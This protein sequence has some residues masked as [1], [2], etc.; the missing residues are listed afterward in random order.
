VERQRLEAQA[1]QMEEAVNEM[2]ARLEVTATPP[3]RAGRKAPRL[4]GPARRIE[5][6]AGGYRQN[7][8]VTCSGSRNQERIKR[9]QIDDIERE[10]KELG[11]YRHRPFWRAKRWLE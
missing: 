1:S 2:Q 8:A 4:R 11:Q 9:R 10:I 5:P 7:L 3:V 6:A